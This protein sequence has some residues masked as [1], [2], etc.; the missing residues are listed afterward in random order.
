VSNYK[1]PIIIRPNGRLANQMFQL[2]LALELSKRIGGAPIFGFNLPE[3][4]IK[5]QQ[6]PNPRF[7]PSEMFL[8]SRHKFNLNNLILLLEKRIVNGVVIEGWGMRLEYFGDPQRYKKIFHSNQET[9]QLSKN[10]LLIN[11]RA[12]DIMSGWHPM[13][14]PMAF[15]Y[16]EKIIALTSLSPVFMGQIEEDG[17]SLALKKRFKGARF[18]PPTSP[19]IDFQT[20][21]NARHIVLSISSFA[22]LA[23]WL[24]ENSV[25]VHVPVAGLFDPKVNDTNLLPLADPRYRYYQVPFPL[26]SER[27]GL[28]LVAW[29]ESAG[30]VNELSMNTT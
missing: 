2:M 21:R 10:E 5:G 9:P 27:K 7:L 29:A 25:S 4:G 11:V 23:A 6:T 24:S 28:D 15:S 30:P 18:L 14:F 12:E 8:I 1:P 16:F 17:Y 20:I 22:W 13:Y 26:F 3:W 19:I